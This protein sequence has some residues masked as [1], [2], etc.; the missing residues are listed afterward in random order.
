MPMPSFQSSHT[1][2]AYLTATGKQVIALGL[3]IKNLLII[4][5]LASAH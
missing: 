4:P 2:L 1:H 5:E 3:R